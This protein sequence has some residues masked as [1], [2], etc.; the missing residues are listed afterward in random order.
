[1]NAIDRVMCTKEFCPCDES[2][3]ELYMSYSDDVLREH[4][5]TKSEATMSQSEKDEYERLGASSKI[6]P[7]YFSNEA[8]KTYSR[9]FDCFQDS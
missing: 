4:S 2:N 6:I 3:K 5:R 9:A 7:L 8:G 1:M